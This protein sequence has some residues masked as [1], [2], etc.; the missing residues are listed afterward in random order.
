MPL[1]VRHGPGEVAPMPGQHAQRVVVE[2][3]QA[4]RVVDH[5]FEVIGALLRIIPELFVVIDPV[6]KETD[7][8]S[9]R[10]KPVL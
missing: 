5:P 9:Y 2:V 4:R 3:V 7:G 6:G 10:G 8:G 1:P